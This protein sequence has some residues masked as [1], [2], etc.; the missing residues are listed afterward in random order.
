[1][2]SQNYATLMYIIRLGHERMN[3]QKLQFENQELKRKLQ[4]AQAW[5]KNEVR[6][7]VKNI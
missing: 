2:F 4:I 6:N 5:M 1:M 7:Q 3:L